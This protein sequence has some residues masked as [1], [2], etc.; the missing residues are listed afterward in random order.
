MAQKESNLV[1]RKPV[2]YRMW[3]EN[4]IDA[5]DDCALFQKDEVR[6][7]EA[8]FPN[9]ESYCP[10]LKK[11]GNYFYFCGIGV[12]ENYPK[13]PRPDNPAFRNRVTGHA[14]EK[15]ICNHESCR[16]YKEMELVIK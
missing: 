12:P 3:L 10:K 9:K 7:L 1:G 2:K 4:Q 5:F 8:E 15:C 6:K 14:L 11:E 16:I 13:L